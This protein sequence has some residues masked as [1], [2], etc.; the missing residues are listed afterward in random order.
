MT[1]RRY[2]LVD[3]N[4]AF[5]DN[6][7]EILRDNG[8]EAVVAESGGRALALAGEQRFDAVLTDMRMPSMS[9]AEFLSKLRRLDPGAAALVVTA[10]TRDEELDRAFREG[11]LGVLQKPVPLD[12]LLELLGRARRNG[13]VAVV[14]DDTA[15]AGN[16][17][18]ALRERGFSPVTAVSIDEVQRLSPTPFA[19]LVDLRM[20]GGP[21]GEAARRM[22]KRFPGV[23]V[24]IITAFAQELADLAHEAVFPK[25]FDTEA[26]LAAV[27]EIHGRTP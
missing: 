12:Q 6:L 24:V 8:D 4:F 1:M 3:D 17:A 13:M 27:E 21:D 10:Y 7:A 5:V 25:P 22:G 20:P 18:D 23:P 16:L 15:L 26:L 11:I 14:E 2:L 19:S 9:G